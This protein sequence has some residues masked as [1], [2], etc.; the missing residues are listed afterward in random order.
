MDFTG[1][2]IVDF[3]ENCGCS[4]SEIE[5]RAEICVRNHRV[6]PEWWP[7][8]IWPSSIKERKKK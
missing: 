8:S 6:P 4:Q 7:P 3:W 5:K 1:Y 2:D